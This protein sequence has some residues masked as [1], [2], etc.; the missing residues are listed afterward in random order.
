[1]NLLALAVLLALFMLPCV[2]AKCTFYYAAYYNQYSPTSPCEFII[3]NNINSG[4]QVWYLD[5]YYDSY[6]L[7]TIDSTGLTLTVLQI[8]TTAARYYNPCSSTIYGTWALNWNSDCSTV[9]FTMIEDKCLWRGHDFEA[10]P[11]TFMSMRTKAVLKEV[12]GSDQDEDADDDD[13][14][15]VRHE[16]IHHHYYHHEDDGAK[17][18][19]NKAGKGRTEL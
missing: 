13:D 10:W 17:A 3:P 11:F 6:E 8:S 19:G 15:V 2:Q 7:W 16:H 5:T 18:G 9:T 12:K 1:M 4:N 14:H